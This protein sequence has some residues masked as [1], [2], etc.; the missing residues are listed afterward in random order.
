[1]T[2][3]NLSYNG[4]KILITGGTGFIGHNLANEL[5]SQYEC[6]VIL[7]DDCSNSSSDV[8]KTLPNRP[9]FYEKSILDTDSFLPLLDG[10]NY[11]FH[12]ACKQI[13]SSGTDPIAD[14]KV[15]AESTLR[16]L[17]HLRHRSD[18]NFERFIYAGS[19]SVLGTTSTGPIPEE[20]KTIA[21][22]HYS[23]TKYLGEQYTLLYQRSYGVPTS[24]VRYSNVYGFGQTV[25]NSYCGV[26]GK[27]IHGSLTG[28]PL[29]IFGD[30]EQT[31]DYTFITDA[32]A[33]TLLA[34]VHPMA[35]GD[36]FNL[37]TSV[38]TSVNDLV[39]LIRECGNPVDVEYCEERDIDNIRRR[40]VD[41][42]KI[43]Q[44]LGWTP[45]IGIRKGIQA[46]LDWYRDSLQ[47]DPI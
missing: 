18:P 7:V 1:M 33:A 14:L 26:L 34:G 16:I 35:L 45:K 29:K 44:R 15:N 22:S 13:A 36:V 17:S 25:Q 19:C 30:G 42:T 40:V 5:L 3:S 8:V 31:R 12:L 47:Q 41:I 6:D 43:Q 2:N 27:F 39:H 21:L 10:V 37:G 23:A 11:I 28:S 9:E 20:T 38:E 46:T 32:V 4:K 24:V